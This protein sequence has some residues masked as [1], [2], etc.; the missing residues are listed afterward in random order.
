MKYKSKASEYYRLKVLINYIAESWINNS[1]EAW[2]KITYSIN[3]SLPMKKVETLLLK[4]R[5]SRTLKTPSYRTSLQMQV[6]VVYLPLSSQWYLTPL[7]PQL[8]KTLIN[9]IPSSLPKIKVINSNNKK[10]RD[11]AACSKH[12]SSLHWGRATKQLRRETSYW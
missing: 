5:R 4:S 6:E 12:P 8:T 1:W 10:Q 9:R 7:I 2:L 11:G 3:L